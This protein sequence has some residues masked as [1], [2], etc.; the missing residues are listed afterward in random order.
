MLLTQLA[1]E[2][3]RALEHRAEGRQPAD[4]ARL[5]QGLKEARE[6]RGLK[7][8]QAKQWFRRRKNRKNK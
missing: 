5:A 6:G 8:H 4:P 2:T 3:R 1:K 7:A